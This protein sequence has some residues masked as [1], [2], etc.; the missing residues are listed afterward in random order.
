M[1]ELYLGLMSGTSMDGVDAVLC[2]IAD[3][4]F[5][6][7]TATHS[8]GYPAA[9]RAALLRLQR[10]KPALT[11]DALARLDNGV[12]QIFASAAKRLLQQ[13]GTPATMVRAIG[14]HGQTVFHDPRGAR[15]TVQLGNPALIAAATAIAVVADFRRA[16]VALGGQGAPLVPAFH[17]ALLADAAEPRCVVNIGGIANITV[18][19]DADATRV[20]GFD[21]GPGNGLMDEWMQARRKRAY[22]RNGAWAASGA[23][24]AKLL[25]ALLGDPWFR[26]KP[27]KSTGRDQFNLAWVQRRFRTLSWLPPAS[28]QR[29]LAELTARTIADAIGRH[30]AGARRV[31]VCGGGVENRVVMQRLRELL[32]S[33]PVESTAASGLDPRHVEAAAFAWLAMRTLNGLPGNLPAV[34]G[35]KRAAV[36]GGIYRA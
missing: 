20:R 7:V 35:A 23:V 4:R 36:L 9:L 22:D 13:T 30:A 29:T 11:L 25:R 32:A 21:T 8:M 31:L 18:L 2:E 24:D 3:G 33:C 5:G 1:T 6:R 10:E 34:T 26:R 19:P 16:D 17:H 28:V 14:S 15:A 27:P 12:A